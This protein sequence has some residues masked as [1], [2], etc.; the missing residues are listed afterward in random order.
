M[1]RGIW[2]YCFLN[3]PLAP[4]SSHD[5]SRQRQQPTDR[6]TDTHRH[7]PRHTHGQR[8]TMRFTASPLYGFIACHCKQRRFNVTELNSES[9]KIPTSNMSTTSCS[10]K[11]VLPAILVQEHVLLV[12]SIL[13]HLPP[14]SQQPFHCHYQVYH[15]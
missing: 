2:R 14:K 11:L 8:L 10:N 1:G 15:F 4:K 3:Y 7:T 12:K 6:L 5:S 13:P 9:R